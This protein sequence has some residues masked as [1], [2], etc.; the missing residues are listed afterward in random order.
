MTM[1]IRRTRRTRRT[2]R[3]GTAALE[4]ALL[5]PVLL[6]LLGGIFEAAW[7]FQSHGSMTRAVRFGCRDGA[8]V[9]DPADAVAVAADSIASHMV[10]SGVQCPDAG[11]IPEVNLEWADTER[12]LSCTLTVPHQ[13]LTGLVPLMDGV[14]FVSATRNRIEGTD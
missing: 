7:A 14:A 4:T 10:D 12:F 8:I 13:S 5:L 11:C 9:Q 1:R 3:S 6:I 2:R